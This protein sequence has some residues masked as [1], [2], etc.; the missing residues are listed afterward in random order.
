MRTIPIWRG[1]FGL[2]VRYWVPQVYALC[3]REP[4]RV[5][6]EEG[7]EALFPATAEWTIVPRAEDESRHGSPP[8]L[9]VK[10]ERF[11]PEP[12]VRQGTRP[13]HVVVCPRWR[14]YGEAKNWAGWP[15]LVMRLQAHGLRPFAAGAPDS[16]IAVGCASAWDYDRF[17]DASI[18]AML[19]ARLVIATDAGLAH[20]AVLCGAD[21]LL[22][23]YRGRVA[24][25]PVVSSSGRVARPEYWSVRVA[26]YYEAANH[27]G[28]RIET[29]DGWESVPRVVEK[30]QTMLAVPA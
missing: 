25:G 23:T 24:P 22:V 21:L 20:L 14:E 19:N 2:K 13:A 8:D 3:R 27:C 28:A 4:C 18:E 5:E 11:V 12:H 16:S 29:V 1:E 26:D 10:G 30:A 15:A 6:I 7:E 9:G 17:L